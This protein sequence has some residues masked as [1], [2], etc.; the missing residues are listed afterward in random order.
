[1]DKY[2]LAQRCI[3]RGVCRE[4]GNEE[5]LEVTG[6]QMFRE[7]YYT[8]RLE[9]VCK[10][11]DTIYPAK[12]YEYELTFTPSDFDGVKTNLDKE[13]DCLGYIHYNKH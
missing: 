5:P 10:V 11:G 2:Q 13:S 4:N 1:M 12:G 6:V 8:V 7:E 9:E 3:M